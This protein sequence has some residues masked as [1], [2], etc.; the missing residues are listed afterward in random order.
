[1]PR[2]QETLAVYALTELGPRNT[3][4]DRVGTAFVNNDGSINVTLRAT[5]TSGRL[6]LRKEAPKDAPKPESSRPAGAS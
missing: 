2:N 6:Q 3:I 1:M 5:P 4:W